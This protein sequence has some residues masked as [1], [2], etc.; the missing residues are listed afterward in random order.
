MDKTLLAISTLSP[1]VI[2]KT[3][4][5]T[6]T[7]PTSDIIVPLG[8]GYNGPI[9]HI[10]VGQRDT[11]LSGYNFMHPIVVNQA[12]LSVLFSQ[13]PSNK[14]MLWVTNIDNPA[15]AAIT[16]YAYNQALINMANASKVQTKTHG[17]FVVPLFE[18]IAGADYI[19]TIGKDAKTGKYYVIINSADYATGAP[20]LNNT[21]LGGGGVPPTIGVKIPNTI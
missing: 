5:M 4:L 10:T 9:T 6:P 17:C 16:L 21:N 13:D 19:V 20:V 8:N 7:P 11:L 18:L 12:Q 15:K 3:K 2:K 1:A 14:I